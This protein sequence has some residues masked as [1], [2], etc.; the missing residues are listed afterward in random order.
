VTLVVAGEPFDFKV[1][2]GD[3]SALVNV[4]ED[5]A[6]EAVRV[7]GW[8][9]YRGS[10]LVSFAVTVAVLVVFVLGFLDHRPAGSTTA[11]DRLA[12][13]VTAVSAGECLDPLGELTGCRARLASFAVARCSD[14]GAADRDAIASIAAQ[15]PELKQVIRVAARQQLCLRPGPLK[16]TG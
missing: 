11:P 12:P 13:H 8:R 3:G 15:L 4:L 7:R 9:K 16:L 2:S 14:V 6:P 10:D 1:R 5:R